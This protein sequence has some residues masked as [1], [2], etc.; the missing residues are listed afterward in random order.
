MLNLNADDDADDD[1]DEQ[2]HLDKMGL[3]VRPLHK[4]H[5]YNKPG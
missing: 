3:E 1:D 2:V 4:I 5:V